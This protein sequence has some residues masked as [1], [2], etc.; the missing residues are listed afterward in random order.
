MARITRT[1]DAWNGI[2][3][4]AARRKPVFVGR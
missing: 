4:V 1:E 3:E 2:C